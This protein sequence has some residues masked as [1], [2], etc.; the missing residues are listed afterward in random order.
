MPSCL[1]FSHSFPSSLAVAEGAF[2][3]QVKGTVTHPV[4]EF[5][6]L[7]QARSGALFE[8]R[9]VLHPFGP[10]QVKSTAGFLGAKYLPNNPKKPGNR[11]PSKPHTQHDLFS[12]LCSAPPV[13]FPACHGRRAAPGGSRS[14]HGPPPRAQDGK[15]KELEEAQ[16]LELNL[17]NGCRSRRLS[18]GAEATRHR[19]RLCGAKAEKAR[20]GSG[21]SSR[22]RSAGRCRSSRSESCGWI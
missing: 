2:S 11:K 1:S 3:L 7:L 16:K 17:H 21:S 18:S 10:D 22:S 14:G 15:F 12:Q 8:V 19:R 20:R 5:L 6:V 4:V 9:Q 13:V